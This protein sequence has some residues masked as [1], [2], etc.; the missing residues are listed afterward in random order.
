MIA[1]LLPRPVIQRR[2]AG[3]KVD[4]VYRHRYHRPTRHAHIRPHL[5]ICIL[6]SVTEFSHTP[7]DGS[8]PNGDRPAF[9][10]SE[11]DMIDVLAA[12]CSDEHLTDFIARIVNHDGSVIL[13]IN[14]VVGNS[15]AEK[16]KYVFRFFGARIKSIQWEQISTIVASDT[17][18]KALI[19]L[20]SD[21]SKIS[22]GSNYPRTSFGNSKIDSEEE[23]L[24]KVAATFQ[25][26]GISLRDIEYYIIDHDNH[27]YRKVEVL[28]ELV[29]TEYKNVASLNYW[30]VD[31]SFKNADESS[32]S[33]NRMQFE[34]LINHI[35]QGLSLIFEKTLTDLRAAKQNRTNTKPSEIETRPTFLNKAT[36][37]LQDQTA[38]LEQLMN[39]FP[40]KLDDR[41]LSSVLILFDAIKPR[42]V[43]RVFVSWRDLYWSFRYLAIYPYKFTDRVIPPVNEQMMWDDNLD[44]IVTNEII[45]SIRNERKELF[46][47]AASVASILSEVLSHQ[48][49]EF[50]RKWSSLSGHLNHLPKTDAFWP[51]SKRL[52]ALTF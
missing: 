52:S 17:A 21:I 12:G 38:A 14:Y 30:L 44:K 24:P 27:A 18:Q 40:C 33:L 15:T 46:Q 35:Y 5:T 3:K 25:I 29:F 32:K 9:S 34:A 16:V 37:L 11:W 41:G 6:E 39:L 45:Y 1:S 7:A 19:N 31:F 50:P 28:S 22:L 4:E 8:P 20:F 10:S 42:H 51:L 23:V 26:S 48:D 36:K 43:D 47:D 2:G 49:R 13:T